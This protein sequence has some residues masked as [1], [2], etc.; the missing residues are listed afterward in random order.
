MIS[1]DF[2]FSVNRN[3]KMQ[4]KCELFYS[5]LPERFIL[6]LEIKF[7]TKRWFVKYVKLLSA[8]NQMLALMNYEM[9]TINDCPRKCVFFVNIELMSFI[10][11]HYQKLY[12]GERLNDFMRRVL[13]KPT[14][15]MRRRQKLAR[16][17]K[18]KHTRKMNGLDCFSLVTYC[19]A[20]FLYISN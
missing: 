14:K 2:H 7:R 8:G 18:L 10:L 11:Q 12:T 19:T 13:K 17:Y 15:N 3:G 1:K 6:W 4:P 16:Q 20:N 5:F 9:S